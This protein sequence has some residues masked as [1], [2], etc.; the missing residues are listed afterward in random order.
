MSNEN[1][2][3][4]QKIKAYH[5][6]IL[7][8]ILCP[9]MIINSNYVNNQR[10]EEKLYKEKSRL[11]NKIILGRNL[12]DGGGAGAGGGVPGADPDTPTPE[13]DPEKS[14]EG[15]KDDTKSKV[16][17]VCERGSEELKKYYKTG[18]LEE[19][20]LKDGKIKCE[21]KDKDYIKAIINI[22]KSKF[23]EEEEGE[24]EE[25]E[26]SGRRNLD[27]GEEKDNSDDK[28]EEGEDDLTNNI[29]AYG[30]HLL[31][32]LIFLVVALLCIPG[33]IMCCFCCCCNCCCCCCCKKPCC[34]IP[35]FVIT[36]GLYALV[37]A[38]CFYGLSQSNH[39]FVGIAD[40]ECSILRFVDEVVDGE[41]KETLPKWAGFNGIKGL[42]EDLKTT[43]NS[44]GSE[45]AT[46][47]NNQIKLIDNEETG[48][49][50]KK[51]LFLKAL[52]EFGDNYYE[53]TASYH[54]DYTITYPDNTGPGTE[55]I[56]V[57]LNGKFVLDLVKQLGK[58]NPTSKD[59]EPDPSIIKAWV[60]EY[61][62]VADMADSQMKTASEGFDEVLGNQIGTIT[63]SLDEG[64]NSINDI[65]SSIGDIKSSSSDIIADNA[66]TI[67]EYGKLGVKAVFGILALID[68]A[69]AAFMLLLCFC[70]G[71]CCTKC[72]CCRC[73]CKL[74]THLLWNILAILMIIV[75]LLGSLFAFIGKVGEDAMSIISFLVSDDN[76]GDG[77]ETILLSSVKEYLG[78]CINGNGELSDQLGFDKDS[79]KNFDDIKYAQSNITY[80]KTQ[81]ESKLQMVTY[82]QLIKNLEERRDFKSPE[83]TLMPDDTNSNNPLPLVTLLE[84]INNYAN[85]DDQNKKEEWTLDCSS[86]GACNTISDSHDDRICF[87][88]KSCTPL[89]RGWIN[90]LPAPTISSGHI[91]Y[92]KEMAKIVK[93][94]KDIIDKAC[95]ETNS[96]SFISSLKI[97]GNAYETFLTQYIIALTEF[98]KTI[99]SITSD[100]NKYTGDDAGI[101]SLINCNF[102]GKNI[103]VMLKYLKEALG[104]DVYTI[105][106]CLIL[107][108][109]SLALSISFTILLII[110]INADIDNNKKK[111]DI[112]EYALNSG[113]RV[114]QYK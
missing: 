15:E 71:K 33:W 55:N 1:K 72:C 96:H 95:D 6:L 58:Y 13:G 89:D 29:I 98:N 70:S 21:D 37:V 113:G 44:L 35:C 80:A 86:D 68:I 92:T 45:T 94:M 31:P 41:S 114:I 23:G 93:D 105:G 19:I 104:G 8:I 88:P 47:L 76:L 64:I 90:N 75:F 52:K 28:S 81:F 109:C 107:V 101:F 102:V 77:K 36:F 73:I 25:G 18:N 39:I 100:I 53:E 12:Q 82:N 83:F 111:K 84:S 57:N 34:K 103:K 43:I 4:S 51:Q 66:G 42:L 49:E 59:G 14:K 27:G 99:D 67:D 60:T 2:K 24:D 112:P 106:V 5:I 46:D 110:V 108:G 10:A 17:E 97:L 65:D 54:N 7:G 50:G 16:D 26:G 48:H 30:K 40:T 9:L 85:N 32:T 20:D 61:K 63:D 3:L 22:L 91:L 79:M 38:V 74:F 11:F 56:V 78:V 62:I 87:Q 69:L